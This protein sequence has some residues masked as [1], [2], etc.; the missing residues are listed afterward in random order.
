MVASGK[1]IDGSWLDPA[2]AE[3]ISKHRL[4]SLQQEDT[5]PADPK[6]A[7]ILVCGASY[8]DKTRA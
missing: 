5:C 6:R 4:Y 2:I 7:A 1:T 3:Y 8:F